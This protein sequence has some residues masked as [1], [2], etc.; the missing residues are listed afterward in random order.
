MTENKKKKTRGKT[1]KTPEHVR[2]VVREVISEI[3][4]DNSQV[5][6]AAKVNQLLQTFLRSLEV[7]YQLDKFDKIEKRLE[8]IEDRMD[9]K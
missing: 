7:E 5:E 1:I 2:K 8:K 6:N 3:Y 4:E 9:K